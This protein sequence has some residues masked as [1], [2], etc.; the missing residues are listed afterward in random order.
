VVLARNGLPVA[1]IV[2][3]ESAPESVQGPRPLG[4]ARGR[5][6]MADNFNDPMTPEELDEFLGS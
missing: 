3:L 6:V 2:R 5:W 1:R 4:F